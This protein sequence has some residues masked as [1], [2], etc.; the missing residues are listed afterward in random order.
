MPWVDRLTVLATILED[1][2]VPTFSAPDPDAAFA[3][4]AACRDA[5][6]RVVEFTNRGD[7]A[8]ATFVELARRAALEAPGVL[9][10]AGTIIDAPTAAM[11]IA[12][13]A[14][15]IVG[16]SFNEEVARLCNRRRVAYMPG[17][18]TAT[19]VA[20]AEELGCEI[21]KLFPVAAMDGPA[22][23]RG[24]HGPS[25][26]S[27]VMPTNV[28]ATEEATR[29]WIAAGAAA[30]GVG[31]HLLPPSLI[32]ARDTKAMTARVSEYLGWVRAA[33]EARG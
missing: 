31:P 28:E 22:F 7:F 6:S 4:V 32:D 26:A 20:T 11:F 21:V 1:G 15:F 18:W 25:P 12:A 2:A 27:R 30:L 23:I 24:L 13:G 29:R 3:V 17:C 19:E 33:R 8:Y 5:G 16:H 9:V 14:R 10:G